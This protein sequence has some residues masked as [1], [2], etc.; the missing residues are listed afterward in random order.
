MELL[1]RTSN[2]LCVQWGA[3]DNVGKAAE[4]GDLAGHAKY[5]LESVAKLLDFLDETQTHVGVVARYAMADRL[6]DKEDELVGAISL[7][8]VKAYLAVV[9]GGTA[10][11]YT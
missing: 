9:L 3:M 11:D 6:A 7:D 8:D 2:M 10:D 1:G 5:R 4:M